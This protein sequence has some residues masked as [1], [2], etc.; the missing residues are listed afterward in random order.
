MASKSE[1]MPASWHSILCSSSANLCANSRCK[2]KGLSEPD[3][4]AHDGDIDLDRL[5]AA[6]NARQRRDA[7]LSKSIGIIFVILPTLQASKMES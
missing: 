2:D 3:E 6:Q 5:V 7:L 1:W 4:G